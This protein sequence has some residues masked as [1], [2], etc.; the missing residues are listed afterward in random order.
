MKVNELNTDGNQNILEK[1]ILEIIRNYNK[2]MKEGITGPDC[3][4]PNICHGDCCS[5]FIDVP[6]ILAE[7]IIRQGLGK[8]KDFI[9]GDVFSF[10]IRI[11][12]NTG[13]CAFF[14]KKLNG[15]KLHSTDLKP[16]QCWIY[17]T[18]FDNFENKNIK[19]KRADGWGIISPEKVIKAEA[20]LQVYSNWSQTEFV[21]ELKKIKHRLKFKFNEKTLKERLQEIKPCEFAGFKDSWNYFE[22]LQAEGFSLQM[23][24]YCEKFNPRCPLLPD[25]YFDCNNIC[26]VVAN[27]IM[28]FF[29]SVLDSY[30]EKFGSNNGDY[31]LIK[32]SDFF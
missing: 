2:L 17:P 28:K 19:C 4:D 11:D 13:K 18:N 15:C 25:N 23:E 21:I 1:D 20:L 26:E 22:T 31:P 24:K 30:L 10:Q 16:P 7:E 5:I 14:D 8:E 3:T 6:K 27:N 29:N 32:I 9:R 12:D